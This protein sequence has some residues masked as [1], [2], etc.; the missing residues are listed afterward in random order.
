M[1]DCSHICGGY[2][3]DGGKRICWED[4]SVSEDQEVEAQLGVH[5]GR[6]CLLHFEYRI[7]PDNLPWREASRGMDRR[8]RERCIPDESNVPGGDSPRDSR[9]VEMATKARNLCEQQ[10]RK[11]QELLRIMA[12]MLISWSL[13]EEKRLEKKL[14]KPTRVATGRGRNATATAGVA[15]AAAVAGSAAVSAAVRGEIWRG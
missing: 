12:S 10:E 7:C 2:S 5:K 1:V 9:S 6:R 14:R 3:R 11:E 13:E 4:S 15:T 8:S